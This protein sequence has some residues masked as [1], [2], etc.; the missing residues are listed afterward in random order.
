ML[1]ATCPWI[2]RCWRAPV[3]GSS[4]PINQWNTREPPR[5]PSSFGWRP[6]H[7]ERN[8]LAIT[9]WLLL[10]VIAAL[11]Y[12]MFR[13]S[14]RATGI[15]DAAPAIPG[16]VD[17][18]RADL[19]AQLTAAEDLVERYGRVLQ[20]LSANGFYPLSRLAAPK[21]QMKTALLV[22]A[23]HRRT[24]GGLTDEQLAAYSLSYSL[25]AN[26][27]P[28]RAY[29]GDDPAPP[30]PAD[31]ATM[32]PQQLL[33]V[34]AQVKASQLPEAVWEAC[35]AERIELQREWDQRFRELM[36]ALAE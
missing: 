30:G 33:A 29:P 9:I 21:A 12:A 32:T 17:T 6:T 35:M 16:Q 26:F 31:F 3:N 20:G 1:S 34:M 25:L 10:L 27:V 7:A 22:M 15:R 13:Q 28:D 2:R 4:P 19:E 18:D 11:A 5:R 14:R 23:V 36:A 8:I 24:R